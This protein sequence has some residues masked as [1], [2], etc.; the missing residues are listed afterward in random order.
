MQS[1]KK[2]K[3]IHFQKTKKKTA[4][5]VYINEHVQYNWCY[6]FRYI[7]LFYQLIMLWEL[8]Y[9]LRYFWTIVLVYIR[10]KVYSL[11]YDRLHKE[12]C[13]LIVL[14]FKMLQY[15]QT[16]ELQIFIIQK[17]QKNI[18][19]SINLIFSIHEIPFSRNLIN[20]IVYRVFLF[21][22]IPIRTKLQRCDI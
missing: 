18:H 13:V 7:S 20:Y 17:L 15:L 22:Y 3:K 1:N 9:W 5:Y 4:V 2:N 11:F 12:N 19:I 6:G 16:Q 21:Y 8:L 14:V 10:W